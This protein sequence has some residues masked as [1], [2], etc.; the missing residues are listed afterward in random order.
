MAS[1]RSSTTG[2]WHAGDDRWLKGYRRGRVRRVVQHGYLAYEIARFGG[3]HD[4]PEAVGS[5]DEELD[6]A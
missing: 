5:I 6:A 4:V 2:S 1:G 3:R